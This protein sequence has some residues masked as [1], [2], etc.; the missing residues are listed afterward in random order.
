MNGRP[1]NSNAPYLD[2]TMGLDLQ[3]SFFLA[4]LVFGIRCSFFTL[5]VHVG[6]VT[7]SPTLASTGTLTILTS[8]WS[9]LD[10]EGPCR[11]L[12]PTKFACLQDCTRPEQ[13][14]LPYLWLHEWSQPE[15]I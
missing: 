11:D 8:V 13:V 7:R 2:V 15:A 10:A 6:T 9:A 3:R 4:N 5:K 12:N 14:G 1:R